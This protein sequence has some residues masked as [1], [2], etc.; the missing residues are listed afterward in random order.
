MAKKE[1]IQDLKFDAIYEDVLWALFEIEEPA[2]EPLI[3]AL[4]DEDWNVRWGAVFSL[5]KMEITKAVDPLIKTLKD[6]NEHVR[7]ESIEALIEIGKPAVES[8]IKALKDE[9]GLVQTLAKIALE[10]IKMKKLNIK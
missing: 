2:V 1:L 5:G 9:S 4:K 3:E 7:S 10:K 8:L 6:E